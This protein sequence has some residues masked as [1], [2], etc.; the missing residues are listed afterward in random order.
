[1]KINLNDGRFGLKIVKPYFENIRIETDADEKLIC[2]N[3]LSLQFSGGTIMA[4]GSSMEH[5]FD[6]KDGTVLIHNL[7]ASTD[8]FVARLD[9]D[10]RL[11]GSLS[12]STPTSDAQP[13][14]SAEDK[15]MGWLKKLQ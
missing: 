9:A 8:F 14:S 2:L 5:G 7:S 4:K 1:V 10:A 3:D 12:G 15:V 11:S 13:V 6:V